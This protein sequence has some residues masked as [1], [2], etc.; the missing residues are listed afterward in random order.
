MFYKFL[1]VKRF[2]ILIH[3]CKT[4]FSVL[5]K[6]MANHRNRLGVGVDIHFALNMHGKVDSHSPPCRKCSEG[7]SNRTK[8]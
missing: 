7:Y 4:S 1:S 3:L 6:M 8:N 2:K 5:L